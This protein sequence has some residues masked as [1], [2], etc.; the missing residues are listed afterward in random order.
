MRSKIIYIIEILPLSFLISVICSLVI[1]MPITVKGDFA[2]CLYYCKYYFFNT[3]VINE[4]ITKYS[5]VYYLSLRAQQTNS[6]EMTI[7]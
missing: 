1:S 3:L 7:P 4:Q 6:H 2:S 5:K